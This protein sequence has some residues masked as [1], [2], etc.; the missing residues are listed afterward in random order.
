MTP[1]TLEVLEFFRIAEII[2]G[3][4]KSEEARERCLQKRPL[5][6]AGKIAAAKELGRDILSF[7]QADEPL[8]I[9]KSPAAQF[10][11]KTAPYRRRLPYYR[12]TLRGGAFGA[13]SR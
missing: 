3:Y 7:L 1:H 4:C 12:G 9:K 6:D 8:P 2:A 11:I 5:Q 13:A 10:R